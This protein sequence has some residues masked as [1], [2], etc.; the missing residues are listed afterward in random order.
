MGQWGGREGSWQQP[1]GVTQRGHPLNCYS[2]GL[3]PLQFCRLLTEQAPGPKV[4]PRLALWLPLHDRISGA[5][6]HPSP[7][8]GHHSTFWSRSESATLKSHPLSPWL[9]A[10]QRRVVGPLVSHPSVTNPFLRACLD[11]S[12]RRVMRGPSCPRP[13]SSCWSLPYP[14]RA[15]IQL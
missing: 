1:F 9:D 14:R 5:L 12:R 10:Y 2:R 4:D 7:T 13:S 15:R 11:C 3:R 8:W 6:T